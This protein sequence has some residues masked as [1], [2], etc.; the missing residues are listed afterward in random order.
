MLGQRTSENKKKM[1]LIIVCDFFSLKGEF[2]MYDL[3]I[4]SYGM[5]KSN[6]M[7]E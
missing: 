3:I 6:D 1:N 2:R 7:S 5:S 4:K